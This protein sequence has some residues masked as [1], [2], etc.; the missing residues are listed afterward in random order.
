MF[1]NDIRNFVFLG[2]TKQSIP[3]QQIEHKLR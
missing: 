2:K 1:G 3:V